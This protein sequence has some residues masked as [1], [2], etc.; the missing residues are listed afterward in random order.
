MAGD[1]LQSVR[2]FDDAFG[3]FV[4]GL[5]RDGLL[6][7]TVLVVAGDHQA[8]LEDAELQRVWE[9]AG[10][11]TPASRFDLWNLKTRVPLLIRLP[12]A[13]QAGPRDVP[14][15][16]P[17]ITPTVLSLLGATAASGPWLGRDL[18]APGRRLIVFRDG[19][20]TDGQTVRI[21]SGSP[22]CFARTGEPMP[23]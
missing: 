18:T 1:Y 14:A 16:H 5:E 22:E 7:R 10:K 9:G 2:L 21:G 17:D 23:C 20:L 3:I 4:R 8:W 19:S 12:Q 15:G 6:D 13:R 11:T